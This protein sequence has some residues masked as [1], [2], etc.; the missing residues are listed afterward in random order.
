MRAAIQKIK[1]MLPS[2]DTLNLNLNHLAV[3]YAFFLP[4]SYYGYARSF[5]F[6]LMVTLIV[7]RR[8]YR[9]YFTQ[10]FK[11]PL[12]IPFLLYAGMYYIWLIGTEDFEY[13]YWML[14]LVKVSLYPLI[15]YAFLDTRF[16]IRIISAMILGVML[17]E[18]VSYLMFF[19]IIPWEFTLHDVT[20]PWKDGPTDIGFYKPMHNHDPAPF[21]SHEIY[22]PL[23]AFSVTVLVYNLFSQKFSRLIT[24]IS[25]I[26]ILTMT[27]NI[28]IVGG[29]MGYLLYFIMLPSVYFL[30][31]KKI[32]LKM[33]T[34]IL[35]FLCATFF[36]AYSADGIFKKR[37]YYSLNS[38]QKTINNPYDFRSS[39]GGRYGLWYYSL[40]SIRENLF[41][42]VGTGDQMSAVK[43]NIPQKDS[44]LKSLPTIHSQYFDILIQF[45]LV[46]LLIYF[47]L[48]YRSFT[49]DTGNKKLNDIKLYIVFLMMMVGFVSPLFLFYIAMFTFLI[50]V[51]TTNM[52][53]IQSEIK[54]MDLKLFSKY[55]LFAIFS[56][57]YQQLQ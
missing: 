20:L 49:F 40:P 54:P 41:F 8:N 4:I 53:L 13:A 47:N 29:R 17:S 15:F 44:F 33:V 48:L 26:F 19:E 43:S 24:S 11:H 32:N 39:M 52:R 56:Y 57:I 36:L 16:A 35:L 46:G 6:L 7:L 23:L 37:L 34:A 50:P 28:F 9:Y 18:V 5:I 22:G 45:G 14:H 31:A 21:L 1:S 27:T 2:E 10:A 38:I 42:G 51:L 30:L 25:V 3:I 55:A 12:T